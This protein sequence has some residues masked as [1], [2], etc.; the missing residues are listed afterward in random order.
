MV[1][2]YPPKHCPECGGKNINYV[3]LW[4]NSHYSSEPSNP[5]WRPFEGISYDVWCKDCETCFDVF[6]NRHLGIYW[7]D[8]YPEDIPPEGNIH[9]NKILA[10]RNPP[11]KGCRNCIREKSFVGT[12]SCG[13]FHRFG[14]YCKLDGDEEECHKQHLLVWYWETCH[15]TPS[16]WSPSSE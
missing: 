10:Q 2:L 1:E 3:E 7:Y 9:W 11:E 5:E 15:H 14:N 8:L 4:H 6:P 12:S 13:R 16:K